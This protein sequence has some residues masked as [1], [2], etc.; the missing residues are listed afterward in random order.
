MS[1]DWK[2]NGSPNPQPGGFALIPTPASLYADILTFINHHGE[3]D[4]LFDQYDN[5]LTRN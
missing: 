3:I 5:F 4:A 1:V 2:F